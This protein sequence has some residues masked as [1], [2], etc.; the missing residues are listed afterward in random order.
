V[1]PSIITQ[2]TFG[3]DVQLRKP[4]SYGPFN[5]IRGNKQAIRITEGCVNNCPNCYEPTELKIFG[6]PEIKRNHVFIF[7]M[8]LLCKPQALQLIKDLGHRLVN[9]RVVY[10][11][12]VCGIDYRFLTQELANAL[13]ENRFVRI[14]LAWDSSF[15][16]QKKIKA[17]KDLL[18]KAGYR[19]RDIMVFLI[20]NYRI[21]FEENLRK[22]DLLKVWN[23]KACDCYFDGFVMPHVRPIFWTMTEIKTFRNKVRKH[24]MLV[25]F[26]IDPT[27]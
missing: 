2:L 9:G 4:Y 10:Y 7:D 18:L 1:C 12:L 3:K 19:T 8:N 22:L 21:S 20:C 14:R 11:E 23:L 16:N 13:K 17:A 24:N 27:L 25:N 26:G 15:L 6:I 5:K